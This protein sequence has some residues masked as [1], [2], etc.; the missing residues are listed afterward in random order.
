MRHKF[1]KSQMSD[2]D[3][4]STETNRS[5][6]E[7]NRDQDH[8]V[9]FL[10]ELNKDLQNELKASLSKMSPR[11]SFYLNYYIQVEENNINS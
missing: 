5:R 4:E 3:F 11:G 6:Q 8:D 1:Y 2:E 10:N 9:E 7:T